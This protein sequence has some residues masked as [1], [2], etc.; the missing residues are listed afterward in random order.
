M[1]KLL[2]MVKET[3]TGYWND[4]C[5]LEE[6]KYAIDRGATGATTNPAIA[7]NVLKQDFKRYEEFIKDTVASQHTATEDQ[8]A[9]MVV[10]HMGVMGAKLLESVF[11]P[12]KGTG[13]LSLQTNPKYFRNA[14]ELTSQSVYFSSLAKNIQVKIPVTEAGV[15]AIEESTYKGVSIN[16]TVSFALSQAIAA[17]EAVERGLERRKKEK[18]S[19]DGINSVITILGG[20]I[21][22][23]LKIAIPRENQ[24]IEPL[25][26]ELAGIAVIK[27]A[28][29]IFTERG[30]KSKIL[31]AACR[32]LAHVS[33]LMGGG[34]LHTLPYKWQVMYNNSHME[35]KETISDPIPNRIIEQLMEFDEFKKAY[36]EDG[37]TLK[38]F[39]SYGPS[40]IILKQFFE[41]YDDLLKVIRPFLIMEP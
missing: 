24:V 20:R 17:A 21:D 30:F 6:L 7:T 10:E 23:W 27:K 2:Q 36:M 37:L 40:L 41:G 13:R 11:D 8:L 35:I 25:A 1:D 34:I 12:A 4:S 3:N 38:E 18:L 32:N 31:C 14:E 5:H 28:H 26:Y 39:S 22:D 15:Q 16:A 33:D 9:W 29:K 19:T